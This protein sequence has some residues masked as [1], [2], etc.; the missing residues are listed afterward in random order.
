M[1]V[2]ECSQDDATPTAYEPEGD[3]SE[4]VE[5]TG[6]SAREKQHWMLAA[7]AAGFVAALIAGFCIRRYQAKK[8]KDATYTHYTRNGTVFTIL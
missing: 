7:A 4:E 5:T 8:R 1:H 2:N 3:S 6:L